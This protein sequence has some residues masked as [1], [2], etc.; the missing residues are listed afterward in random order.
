MDITRG[1]FIEQFA[2]AFHVQCLRHWPKRSK[3]PH[4]H[5]SMCLHQ[6][7]G[8]SAGHAPMKVHEFHELVELAIDDCVAP[9][10]E[11]SG[12][13]RAMS[14]VAVTTHSPRRASR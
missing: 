12:H 1:R 4:H 13:A 2:I 8:I 7:I 5:V 9:R 6:W 14:P 3:E 10:Q 11:K